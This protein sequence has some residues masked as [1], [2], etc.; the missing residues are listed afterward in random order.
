MKRHLEPYQ[1]NFAYVEQGVHKQALVK[2]VLCDR[3]KGKL[4][5]KK[6]QE[7]AAKALAS[8][9]Q[10]ATSASIADTDAVRPRGGLQQDRDSQR[11]D[12]SRR[13]EASPERREAKEQERK[14]RL[15]RGGSKEPRHKSDSYR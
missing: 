9:T 3:C 10:A 11:S 12:K 8:E 5:Y 4:T 14:Y 7:R 13:R 15:E 2:V 1:L 6:D